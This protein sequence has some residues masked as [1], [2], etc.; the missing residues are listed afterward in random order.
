MRALRGT[1]GVFYGVGRNKREGALMSEYR[2]V[3]V[4][5]VA[6]DIKL[7]TVNGTTILTGRTRREAAMYQSAAKSTADISVTL[8]RR[9]YYSEY[10][11]PV[12]AGCLARPSLAD[13]DCDG[14]YDTAMCGACD[15]WSAWKLRKLIPV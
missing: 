11:S 15:W 5:T 10:R 13:I 7:T 2:I 1:Y 9:W 3:P 4:L 8:T 6:Y 12:C 14:C